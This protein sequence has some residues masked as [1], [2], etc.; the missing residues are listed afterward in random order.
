MLQFHATRAILTRNW[1]RMAINRACN[2]VYILANRPFPSCPVTSFPS[3]AKCKVIY[4]KMIFLFSCFIFTRKVLHLASFRKWEFLEL[5]NG[6]LHCDLVA[7]QANSPWDSII[8]HSCDHNE[9][10][11]TRSL[12]EPLLNWPESIVIAE[13]NWF[14]AAWNFPSTCKES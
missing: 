6:L 3:K 1:L 5:G 7:Q 2:D 13:E 14:Q 8:C 12:T 10:S 4:R 11:L 9:W